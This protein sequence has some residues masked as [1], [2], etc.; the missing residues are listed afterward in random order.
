MTASPGA[1]KS[2]KGPRKFT[3]GIAKYFRETRSEFK[4][5]VWPTRK[6]TINNTTVVLIMLAISG[7][8]VWVLDSVFVKVLNLLLQRA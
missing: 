3:R 5:I 6:Q 4:K 8:F 7:L 1:V 2:A